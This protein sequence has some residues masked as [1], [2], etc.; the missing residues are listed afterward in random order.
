MLPEVC[1]PGTQVGVTSAYW[2]EATGIPAG[3]PVHAGATDGCV[4]Q[5]GAGTL[6][7]GEWH[8]VLGTTLVLKGVS[9]VPIASHEAGIYPH[10]SPEDELWFPGGASNAGA[11]ALGIMLPDTDLTA[12][13]T[14][15]SASWGKTVLPLAYPVAGTGER[16]PINAPAFT[17][18]L[19]SPTSDAAAPLNLLAKHD[20]PDIFTAICVGVACVER[21]ALERLSQLG[22]DVS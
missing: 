19:L 11:G 14:A 4:A 22:V 6:E 8:A 18:F 7:P 10:R 21:L 17:G 13:S 12:L 20:A 16:F 5:F 2:E 9:Q 3:V 15:A 1:A